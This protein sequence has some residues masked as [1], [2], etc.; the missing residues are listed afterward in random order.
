VARGGVDLVDTC[1]G[2]LVEVRAVE[3]SASV[4]GAVERAT[5]LT[6]F[7][8]ESDELGAGRSPY[9]AAVVGHAVDALGACEWSVFADDLGGVDCGFPGA[10]VACCAVHC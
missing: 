3:R 9:T 6:A 10:A 2:D 5:R 4:A 1:F 8:I 7:R